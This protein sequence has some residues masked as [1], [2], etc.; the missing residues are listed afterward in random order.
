LLG[1]RVGPAEK[2]VG[3]EEDGAV[4]ADERGDT[5][6][7]EDERGGGGGGSEVV[8]IGASGGGVTL[9]AGIAFSS[10]SLSLYVNLSV[11]ETRE[12]ASNEEWR[13]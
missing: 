13:E 6:E 9:I 10:L 1:E 11:T 8:L 5:S 7:D 12:I 2:G 3:N 4:D